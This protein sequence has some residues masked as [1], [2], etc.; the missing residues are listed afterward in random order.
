[1]KYFHCVA[2]SILS[3]D[4]AHFKREQYHEQLLLRAIINFNCD[5]LPPVFSVAKN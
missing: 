5:V 3:V 4:A 1:M 2:L